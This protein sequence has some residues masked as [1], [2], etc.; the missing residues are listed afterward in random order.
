MSR[1]L[2]SDLRYRLRALFGGRQME[3]ELDD[4]LQFHL[5]AQTDRLVREGVTPAEAVRRARIA[6]GGVEH[7]KELSRDGRGVRVALDVARDFAFAMRAARRRPGFSLIV[8]L[9]LA[10]GIGSTTAVFSLTYD[11]LLAPL[12]LPHPEQLAS[13]T[14]ID[15]DEDDNSFTWAEYAALRDTPG[16]GMFSAVRSASAIS[17][18]AGEQRD[19]INIHFVD[20]SYFP[21][22]GA[23][24]SQGRLIS[25]NDDAFGAPVVVL[26][27][28]FADKLFPGDSERIGKIVLIRGAPFTVIGVTERPFLALEFP[29]WFTAAIP[30]GA[31]SLL[32]ALGPGSDNRGEPFGVGD[33]R[34]SAHRLFRVVARIPGDLP[35]ARAALAAAFQRCCRSTSTER[36]VVTEISR[37]IGGGKNDFRVQARG[38]LTILLGG[39]ALVLLVVCANVAGLL[40]VRESAR[41]REIAVR[42]ALGASR[43][44]IILQL[45]M[46]NVPLAIAGG[47]GG[48]A[49]AIW[50]S[51]IFMRNIPPD[52]ATPADPVQLFGIRVGPV[53]VGCTAAL[54]LI[55]GIGFS[56]YPALRAT[57]H[58]LARS[59]RLDAR[60]SRTRKQGALAR[61][62]VA[63]QVAVTLALVTAGGLFAATIGNLERLDGGFNSGN[64]LLAGLEARS[65]RYEST[66]VAPLLGAVVARVRN[67][68][69]V[70]FAAAATSVPVF[71]GNNWRAIAEIPGFVPPPG[72]HASVALSALT[73]GYFDALGVKLVTG[74]DFANT[75][76]AGSEPVA[77]VSS[78]FVRKYLSRVTPLGQSVAV[79][80]HGDSLIAV[81]IV[82]VAPDVAS[83]DLRAPAAPLV[84][85]PFSQTTGSW[86]G[87]MLAIR[88]AG[89]PNDEIRSTL[90]AIQASAPGL[91]VRNVRDMQSLRDQA[92]TVERLAARLA[93]FVSAMALLLSAVGLYGVV[94]YSVSQRTSEIGIR[95]ALGA[96]R[97]SVLWLVAREAIVIVAAGV[98]VG[99]PLSYATGGALRSQLFGIGVHN[100]VALTVAVALLAGVGLAASVIPASRATQIDPRAALNAD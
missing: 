19:L 57:R 61:G 54:T 8:A 82:G 34:L 38:I 70:R 79:A 36:L 46:E 45:V 24:A 68:P 94:A 21:L 71:G 23:R 59:L 22:T 43:A 69:G 1:E 12:R 25:A 81:R 58:D 35:A 60:A 44:R 11:V 80:S 41:K 84:Y 14:R 95:L 93:T 72:K 9:S 13:L 88:T 51:A 16:A 29:G 48:A 3:R 97:G 6:I 31:V 42:L 52:W 91:N 96:R 5:D 37:G 66:G 20:G 83:G 99:I 2:L 75:D 32:G 40:L 89:N 55:C 7:V 76:D 33:D 62:V 39:M 74:R 17:I 27:A 15:K 90:R 64:L 28:W 50:Y 56:I 98:V 86:H 10:L 77:I 63:A 26:S 73:P 47:V 92:T 87:A 18:V 67:E 85:V 53:L 78:A 30:H 4:E 65:S 100:P 49:V